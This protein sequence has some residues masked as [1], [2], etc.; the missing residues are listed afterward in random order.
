MNDSNPRLGGAGC[1]NSV[2]WIWM[3]WTST[4]CA[5]QSDFVKPR[6]KH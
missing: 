4:L 6:P 5:I 3:L 2:G 1:C